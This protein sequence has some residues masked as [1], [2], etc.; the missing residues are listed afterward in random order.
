ML[1]G[2]DSPSCGQPSLVGIRRSVARSSG[3]RPRGLGR[4][5]VCG[6]GGPRRG[7]LLPEGA[8]R[9][10]KSCLR[11]ELFRLRG[12][13]LVCRGRRRPRVSRVGFGWIS[14]SAGAE[15]LGLFSAPGPVVEG[16]APPEISSPRG[17][18]PSQGNSCRPPRF[19]ISSSARN[20]CS[21]P[22]LQLV[23]FC[24]LRTRQ[25]CVCVRERD[26][27]LSACRGW[28]CWDG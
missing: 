18:T 16:L 23:F 12:F 22:G 6:I 19:W 26:W 27:E 15:K 20:P 8:L 13:G 24:Y 4:C 25:L 1:R 28:C 5:Q 17:E 21:S 11:E 9:G 7:D 10:A 3:L 14:C 2:P